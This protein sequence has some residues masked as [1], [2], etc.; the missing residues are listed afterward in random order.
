MHYIHFFFPLYL[1]VNSERWH[2]EQTRSDVVMRM[3]KSLSVMMPPHCRRLVHISS[4]TFSS[5][6]WVC[7]HCESSSQRT[8]S[9]HAES[10]CGI[11]KVQCEIHHEPLWIFDPR[12]FACYCMTPTSHCFWAPCWCRRWNFV[13]VKLAVHAQHVKHLLSRHATCPLSA[14][15]SALHLGRGGLEALE[16]W[17]YGWCMN[18]L[19]RGDRR[20]RS[21]L[22]TSKALGL[23]SGTGAS[24]RELH[25]GPPQTKAWSRPKL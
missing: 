10:V 4:S 13:N 16:D 15:L 24:H 2:P 25:K 3:F 11:C 6:Q 23:P 12:V 8:R 19:E 22:I 18:N 17:L 14:S 20:D 7:K 5:F 21:R 9:D 1:F